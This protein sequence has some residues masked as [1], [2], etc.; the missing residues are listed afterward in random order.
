M[1][2]KVLDWKIKEKIILLF[3]PVKVNNYF[4]KRTNETLRIK[5][6]Q[7]TI[8]NKVKDSSINLDSQGDSEYD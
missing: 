2:V 7:F 8:K 5:V 3:N 4:K 1:Q 6:A